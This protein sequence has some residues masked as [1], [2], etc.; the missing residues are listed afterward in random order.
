[1]SSQHEDEGY[2]PQWISRERTGRDQPG[3]VADLLSC[4]QLLAR[5]PVGCPRDSVDMARAAIEK[6]LASVGW[7][8]PEK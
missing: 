7:S 8:G 4:R 6:A 1:M 3:L 5:H 2:Q